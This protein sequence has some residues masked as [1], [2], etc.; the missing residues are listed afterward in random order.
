MSI[1]SVLIVLFWIH[2][3]LTETEIN[4]INLE[5]HLESK[6]ILGKHCLQL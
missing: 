3:R 2:S 5:S 6:K 4:A 1:C